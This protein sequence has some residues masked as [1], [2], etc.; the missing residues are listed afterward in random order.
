MTTE[1]SIPSYLENL[2]HKNKTKAVNPIKA[3]G[4]HNRLVVILSFFFTNRPR[5]KIDILINSGILKNAEGKNIGSYESPYF[6]TLSQIRALRYDSLT[7]MWE[8]GENFLDYLTYIVKCGLEVCPEKIKELLTE[9]QI[10]RINTDLKG[11][12]SEMLEDKNTTRALRIMW[13]GKQEAIVDFIL[14]EDV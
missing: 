1:I 14:N 9:G 3:F 5:R 4:K 10:K 8:R 7:K 12:V 6:Q 2:K 11:V 13:G